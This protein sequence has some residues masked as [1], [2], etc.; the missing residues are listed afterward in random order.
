ML[1]DVIRRDPLTGGA[2]TPQVVDDLD[3][4]NPTP[5]PTPAERRDRHRR[6]GTGGTVV[7]LPSRTT[8][9]T[10]GDS[11]DTGHR[12]ARTARAERVT[13]PDPQEPGSRRKPTASPPAPRTRAN[14]R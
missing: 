11:A 7:P 10:A 12:H 13:H 3:T 9:P 8:L 2:L 1:V 5:G 6:S 14:R 4:T